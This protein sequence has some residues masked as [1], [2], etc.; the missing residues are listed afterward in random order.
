MVYPPKSGRCKSVVSFTVDGSSI[1][2]LTQAASTSKVL[3]G[4]LFPMVR[5]SI[6][7]LEIFDPLLS[8]RTWRFVDDELRSQPLSSPWHFL[9]LELESIQEV[10]EELGGECFLLWRRSGLRFEDEIPEVRK[11]AFCG[12]PW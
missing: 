12:F 9:H 3:A 6:E 2:L 5:W 8:G 7:P 11:D 1:D 4:V 10:V